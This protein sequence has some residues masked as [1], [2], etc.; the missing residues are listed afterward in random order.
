MNGIASAIED[1]ESKKAST[2]GVA[3]EERYK[4]AVH[5]SRDSARKQW[6]NTQT[7]VGVIVEVYHF[8]LY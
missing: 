3:G 4:V 1:P 2:D 5:H 8:I 7:L 6:M